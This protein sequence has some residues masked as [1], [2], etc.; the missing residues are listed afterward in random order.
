MIEENGRVVDVEDGY[1]W[2]ETEPASACGSCAAGRGCG[3]SA[4]AK[5]FGHRPAPLRVA[6]SINAGIG[7]RSNAVH[8]SCATLTLHCIATCSDECTC[9]A[10]SFGIG[11]LV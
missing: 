6:N 3:T 11:W 4:L 2:I 8:Y 9:V 7:D 10:D 5:L 1:A